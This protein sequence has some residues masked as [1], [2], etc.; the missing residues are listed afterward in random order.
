MPGLIHPSS[1]AQT[2]DS[3]N[4]AMFFCRPVSGAEREKVA[5]WIV[6]RQGLPGAYAA[7]FALFDAERRAG[8]RVFTGERA[9]SASGRHIIGEEAC[10]VLRQLRAR[11]KPVAAAVETATRSLNI[12]P[13]ELPR[14]ADPKPDDGR[15]HGFWPYRG[16]TFCCGPCSVGLWRHLLAG[17]F[18]AQERRLARGVKCLHAYRKGDGEWRSFPFWYTVLALEEMNVEGSVDELRYAAPR[19]ERVLARKGR[20]DAWSLR[21]RQLAR[22]VLAKV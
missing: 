11:S 2:V 4:E 22:L 5:T 20:E 3:V 12:G 13:A 21:R 9:G 14:G 1:L 7:T 16:G 18:D 10:R 15:K 6:G 17:G 8:I 19:C